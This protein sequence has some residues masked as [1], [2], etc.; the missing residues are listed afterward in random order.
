MTINNPIKHGPPDWI[1]DPELLSD[2]E[3]LQ[4]WCV[5]RYGSELPIQ[6]DSPAEKVLFYSY[7]CGWLIGMCLLDEY[8]K[9]PDFELRDLPFYVA[10]RYS[11]EVFKETCAIIGV[12]ELTMAKV[13]NPY[14]IR[15][16]CAS[17]IQ[18]YDPEVEVNEE[19]LQLA[20]TMNFGDL[21]LAEASEGNAS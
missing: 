4:R 11:L 8:K 12:R 21:I 6:G 13:A 10:S 20:V 14:F 17:L 5:E 1:R 2:L 15:L 19:A 9:D 18:N 16:V 7:H 3:R